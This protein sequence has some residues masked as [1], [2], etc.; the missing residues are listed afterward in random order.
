MNIGESQFE[1][2]ADETAESWGDQL[3]E[4]SEFTEYMMVA[5]AIKWHRY[6]ELP[7]YPPKSWE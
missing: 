5:N 1:P 7:Q 3:P 6:G 2:Q 4:P